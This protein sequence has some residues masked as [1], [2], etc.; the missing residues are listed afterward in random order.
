[1]RPFFDEN[2]KF[3]VIHSMRVDVRSRDLIEQLIAVLKSIFLD[4]PVRKKV[5]DLIASACNSA[6]DSDSEPVE[7]DYWTI[8]VF[9]LFKYA[10]KVNFDGMLHY[11]N[12]DTILRQLLGYTSHGK[13]SEKYFSR[14]MIVGS[15]VRVDEFTL[16][17]INDEIAKLAQR[18][19]GLKLTG[20]MK[21]RV[22]VIAADANAVPWT[23]VAY[24]SKS[25]RNVVKHLP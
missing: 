7:L 14:E 16:M 2:C 13:D 24:L 6:S 22:G 8:L 10:I 5:L 4:E 23:D 18:T 9:S 15:L 25:F 20:K 21:N 12:Y 11:A 17:L 1:M 19:V 3:E